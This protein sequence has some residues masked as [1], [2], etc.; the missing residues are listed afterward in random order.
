MIKEIS[1]EDRYKLIEMFQDCQYDRVLIDSVLEGG[2]GSSSAIIRNGEIVAA[3]LD[4]GAFTMLA[5]DPEVDNLNELLSEKPI[6]IVTAQN[7]DWNVKLRAFLGDKVQEIPF[8]QFDTE[9]LD[10]NHLKSIIEGLPK[11]Y[12]LKE[13]D[14]KL[15]EKAM[16]DLK[17]DYLFENFETVDEYLSR[18]IG[19]CI[20]HEGLVVSAATSMAMS[21]S[22]LDI[23]IV[24][25]QDYRRKGLASA[26]GAKLVLSSLD[27]GVNPVW[28][29]ANEESEKLAMKLGFV[30][31]D[32]YTSL[33]LPE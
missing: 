1:V 29:A 10:K 12:E 21:K 16:V 2:F 23:E 19:Y 5:G 3:R 8:T 17:N 32:T 26:V 15:A 11:S 22:A 14:E 20:T 13:F 33:Y 27:K 9:A 6:F 18:G 25:H 4:S 28:L 7:A 30:K 24:T 31:L